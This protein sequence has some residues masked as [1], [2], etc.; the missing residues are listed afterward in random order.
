LTGQGTIAECLERYKSGNL[1][2]VS[3][4]TVGRHFGMRSDLATT[5]R[6]G[7]GKASLNRQGPRQGNGQGAGRGAGGGTGRCRRAQRGL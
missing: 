2:A 7:A 4:P 6:R 1:Q 3:R 5:N